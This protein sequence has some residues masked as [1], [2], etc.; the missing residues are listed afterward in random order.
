M[1]VL[2]EQRA[3]LSPFS[4]GRGGDLDGTA[5]ILLRS[6]SPSFSATE[7][8]TLGPRGRLERIWFAA[9]WT[10]AVENKARIRALRG[11][12]GESRYPRERRRV[13]YRMNRGMREHRSSC[14]PSRCSCP[15]TPPVIV[16]SGMKEGRPM[17]DPL[18][19]LATDAPFA[20]GLGPSCRQHHHCSC[21]C[22]AR[23]TLDGPNFFIHSRWCLWM[24]LALRQLAPHCGNATRTQ[25]L[26]E[27]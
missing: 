11:R 4:T 7:R 14:R 2:N 10:R 9:S 21:A 24:C 3:L 17:T 6:D 13:S 16:S 23:T 22:E 20:W 15:L 27:R 1:L 18:S 19:T 8:K 12:F 5:A 26:T 25:S